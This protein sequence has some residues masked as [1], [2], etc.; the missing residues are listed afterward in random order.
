ME[1][2]LQK[3]LANAGVASRRK[4]EELITEGRVTVNGKTITE[5]GAKAGPR[6]EVA[7]DGVPA[8][9]A[10][11]KKKYVML[12]KPEGVVTT[13]ADEFDRP[14]VMDYAPDG[15]RLFPVGR[16]DFESSGLIFL[17]NDGDWANRLT[18]PSHEI[19][20]TYIAE[21]KG[22]PTEKE[23]QKFRD[24]IKIDG[25]KTAPAEIDIL[26]GKSK[27]TRVRITIREGRN[28][29]VRKMCDAIG[30]SVIS[31]KRVSVGDVRLGDLAAGR[32]RYLTEGEVNGLS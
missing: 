15:K 24:G 13:T 22:E 10:P 11:R 21:I 16:L 9:R 23:L 14:T 25:R 3:I 8:G 29:Q 28:R 18:H 12:H 17:T 27:N 6:D 2:R 30:H 19:P 7:V 1:I 32:W 31:L 4:A 26:R 20:K 5:L